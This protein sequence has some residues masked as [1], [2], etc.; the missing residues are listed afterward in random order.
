MNLDDLEKQ[1][2]RDARR[3]M[4]PSAQD[5]RR[6][7]AAVAAQIGVAALGST[8]AVTGA[9]AAVTTAATGA[10]VTTAATGAAVSAGTG[11]AA[12]G[13]AGVTTAVALRSAGRLKAGAVAISVIAMGGSLA[14]WSHR[15]GAGNAPSVSARATTSSPT[16]SA[17]PGS[18]AP[19]ENAGTIE[20]PTKS[21][22]AEA[23]MAPT[24]ANAG[25]LA[26]GQADGAREGGA[27]RVRWFEQDRSRRSGDSTRDRRD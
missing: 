16:N 12:T 20:P 11:A 10:A 22:L 13:A 26:P 15:R 14:I 9:G 1:V 3:E 19:R 24:T 25:P 21:D 18:V 8:V 4:S 7:L 23:E 5:T 27:S 17:F 6:V 2:L